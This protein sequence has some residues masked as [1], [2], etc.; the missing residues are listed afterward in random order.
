[1][2]IANRNIHYARSQRAIMSF[3]NHDSSYLSMTF[4]ALCREVGRSV[5]TRRL[6]RDLRPAPLC[7]TPGRLWNNHPTRKKC[8]WEDS[9]CKCLTWWRHQMETSSALLAI[10]A[11]NSPVPGEFPA[12]RPVT[13]SFDVFFDLRLNKRLSKQSWGWWFMPLYRRTPLN[14]TCICPSIESSS[15]FFIWHWQ[16]DRWYTRWRSAMV[17]D[18]VIEHELMAAHWPNGSSFLLTASEYAML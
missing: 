8:L 5:W 6:S 11:G 13:R 17:S 9:I 18:Q 2:Q 3:I 12:Q 16:T 4:T 1:M 14:K 10:C 7:Q 15:S